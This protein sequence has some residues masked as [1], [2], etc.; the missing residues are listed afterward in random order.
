M[1]SADRRAWQECCACLGEGDQVVLLDA[2]VMLLADPEADCSFMPFGS[3][4]VSAADASARGL[5]AA[6]PVTGA[7]WVS[8]AEIVTLLERHSH[9][10]SWR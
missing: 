10:L 6:Q 1:L 2:G 3:L 8:D 7:H 5:D 9:C 4:A